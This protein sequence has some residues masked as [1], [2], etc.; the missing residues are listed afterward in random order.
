MADCLFPKSLSEIEKIVSDFG[1][2]KF[3][4]KQI[5]EWL[6]RGCPDFSLMKNISTALQR[7]LSESFDALPVK[8]LLR[9]DSSDGQ[10]TKFLFGLSDMEKIECALMRT[11]YGNSI[12]VSSQVGCAMN[13]KFCASAILGLKRNL[14]ADE[15]YA[16]VLFGQWTLRQGGGTKP[17]GDKNQNDI[18]HIVI[19]GSGEPLMNTQN[20]IEFMRRANSNLGIGWRRITLSTCGI[21]PEIKNLCKSDRPF[22]LAISLHAPNDEIRKKI[23]PIANKY[24]IA[25]TLAAGF[26][27]SSKHNRQLMIEYNLIGALNDSEKCAEELALLLK[28]KLCMV[29]LI[30]LNP[31]PELSLTRPSNNQVHRFQ[32]IL[33]SHGIHSRIRKERGADI[34]SA[35]GQLRIREKERSCPDQ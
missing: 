17:N 23:M 12:C 18:T 21:V 31:V 28:N 13:C 14:T 3:R 15:M 19:M 20:V 24:S 1:E 9:L 30:P 27:F 16:E 5:R 25:D 35:C 8:E 29:N 22:N 34:D 33:L 32:D 26:E 11:S 7:K 10:T 2:A 4:A 6:N